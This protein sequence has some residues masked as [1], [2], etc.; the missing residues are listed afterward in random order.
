MEQTV[1]KQMRWLKVYVVLATVTIVVLLIVLIGRTYGVQKFDEITVERLNIVEADGQLKMV[2]SNQ[3]RQ[4]P[5]LMHNKPL[6]TRD[7][8]AGLVFF[9]SAGDECGGLI[10]DS[11]KKEASLTFSVDQFRSDQIMQLQYSQELA[12]RSATKH[13]GLKLWERPDTVTLEQLMQ[14]IDSLKNLNNPTAYQQ[15]IDQMQRQ[16]LL[17]QERLFVGRNQQEEFGVFIRDQAGKP[18]IRL[19]VDKQGETRL[20]L[21]KASGKVVTF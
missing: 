8:P 12:R 7:R 20:E 15:G 11:D 5:G 1:M 4:H 13:Y 18:R 16:Q 10:Y 9:N 14:R 3:A 6:P 2:I 21:R 19:Y 17:G